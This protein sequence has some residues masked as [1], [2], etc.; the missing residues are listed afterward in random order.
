MRAFLTRSCPLFLAL[1][2]GFLLSSC[3]VPLKPLPQGT[4]V[5]FYNTIPAKVV[6]RETGIKNLLG[7]ADV[8]V[9]NVP[10]LDA[11][12]RRVVMEEARKAGVNCVYVVA[13]TLEPSTFSFRP[14]LSALEKKGVK[15]GSGVCMVAT[16]GKNLSSSSY[17]GVDSH[18]FTLRHNKPLIPTLVTL[19]L[20]GATVVS[21]YDSPDVSKEKTSVIG[22]GG[23]G[24]GWRYSGFEGNRDWSDALPSSRANAVRGWEAFFREAVATAFGN[25]RS[26]LAP[27]NSAKAL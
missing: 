13:P 23:F 25:A 5:H 17:G 1:S 27:P 3:A 2:F 8:R 21:R 26:K 7:G 4:K 6:V 15:V 18:G 9:E 14:T 12:M 10:E 11:M 20:I 24:W 22:L 16:P 19:D